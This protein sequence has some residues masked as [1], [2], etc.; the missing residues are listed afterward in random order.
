M[1]ACS[2][3]TFARD[4]RPFGKIKQFWEGEFERL[5]DPAIIPEKTG[6]SILS[7]NRGQTFEFIKL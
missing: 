6:S 7:L 4:D 1:R 5:T 2:K 3:H